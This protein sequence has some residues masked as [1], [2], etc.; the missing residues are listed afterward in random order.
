MGIAQLLN[1]QRNQIVDDEGIALDSAE[2]AEGH[3]CAFC[4]GADEIG[5]VGRNRQHV[6]RLI[7]TEE[8]GMRSTLA[9]AEAD[10]EALA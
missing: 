6:T 5:D 10:L 7:L 2:A 3:A 8:Q 1:W 9:F 4:V